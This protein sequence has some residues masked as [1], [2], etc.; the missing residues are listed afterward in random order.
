MEEMFARRL[1]DARASGRRARL[2]R[3]EMLGLLALAVS[4]RW[5]GGTGAARTHEH[6]HKAGRMDRMSQ[7][8]RHAAR[9]LLRSPGFTLTAVATLALAIAANAAIFAVV[10]RVVLNPLPYPQS[11]QLIE[12][13]HG[14]VG[15]RVGAGLG[16]TAGLYFHY[17]ERSRT[18]S[19]AA[20]YRTDGRTI[21]GEGEPERIRLARVTTALASVLR[22]SP[23]IGRWFTEAE[24]APGAAPAAVLSHNLWTRRYGADPRVIG[25]QLALDGVPTEVV[26][27]MPPGF[28]FPE[29]TVEAWIAEPLNRSMGFGLWTY[30][31]VARLRDGVRLD[32]VRTELTGLIAGVP[33]AFPGDA[34]AL[35]NVETKLMFT[36]RTLKDATIGGVARALWILLASVGVVLLVACANVANLFLVRSEARQR[37]VAVRRA[38]GASRLGIAGFFLTE[39]VLLAVAGGALGLLLAAGA[40]RLLIAFGPATLPRMHEIRIDATT[41]SFTAGLSLLAAIACGAL[42]LWRGAHLARSL[43]GAGRANTASRS[44]HRVRHVL[45]GAQVALALVL[46]V[47][48]GLMVRSLQKLRAMNPGFDASSALT[49]RLALPIRS[50]SSLAADVATHHAI[51]DR[52]AALPGVVRASATSCLPLSGGCHGNSVRIEGRSIPPGAAPPI[53]LFR[54]VAGDYFETIGTRV[55]RGRGISRG[56]VDHAEPIV[57]VSESFGK[58]NFPGED[59]IGRRVASNRP[60]PRIGQPQNLVWQTIVGI[61]ADTPVRALAEPAP[62]PQLFMPMSLAIEPG[63]GAVGPDLIVMTYVVRTTPPPLSVLTPVRQAIDGVDRAL[64]LAGVRT[65]QD[66]LDGAAGQ[67]AFTMVLLAIAAGVT[68][69]LGAIGTYGVMSYIVSQRTGEIGVRLALGAEPGNV[70]GMIARQGGLVALVGAAVGLGVALAGS[71]LIES[72]LYN[73]SPRDPGVFAATTALLV[74]VALAACWLPARRASRLSPMEALRTE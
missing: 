49:F 36:G 14:S 11:D 54:A 56:D 55:L 31:G 25:R 43:H 68:L 8:L 45:M 57:V 20:L 24:G 1:A 18:I 42:P 17:L 59:P 46:L 6:I 51:L 23:A 4:E 22:V 52:I 63:S 21:S 50:Y 38:L 13:D 15:L 53:A 65:L 19:G 66:V 9:R 34:T 3:R 29:P 41:L 5:R 62:I 28:A 48:S 30:A 32:A 40:V 60:P 44:T 74:A 26:G 16:T 70:A 47:G 33:A 27:V 37:E 64:A 7:E 61:V 71:R 2:W 58:R 73:V 35:G 39:S 72:L 67:M 69:V 10:E 12:L